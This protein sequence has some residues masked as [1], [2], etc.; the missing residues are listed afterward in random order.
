MRLVRRRPACRSR[1]PPS[2]AGGE[3]GEHARAAADRRGLLVRRVD[4]RDRR[5]ARL[6]LSPRDQ[7]Q[8]RRLRDR[9][10]ALL[11]AAIGELAPRRAARLADGAGPA[12][13]RRR[14]ARDRGGR[15][16]SES[17]IRRQSLR[18][19]GIVERASRSR[20]SRPPGAAPPL[21]RPPRARRHR[22]ASSA[23]RSSACSARTAPARRRRSGSSTRCCRCRRGPRGARLRRARVADGGSPA[24][25]LRPAAAVD[26]GGA[27][28]PRER[29]LVR[30]P[31]RRAAAR[32]RASASTTRSR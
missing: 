26:R 19:R 4:R 25:R 32:A 2:S 18:R 17:R 5:V 21:R 8:G 24:A 23:A 27:D 22:P 28:R 9:R 15:S 13:A 11:A 31:L 14:A 20:P 6:E 1:R 7:P 16:V 12:G 30:A 3:H 10:V 29:H